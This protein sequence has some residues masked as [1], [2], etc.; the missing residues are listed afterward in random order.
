M[1]L[2]NLY[3][4]STTYLRVYEGGPIATPAAPITVGSSAAVIRDSI[5]QNR[6]M[7][8]KDLDKFLPRSGTYTLEVMHD[9]PFG[10]DVLAQFHPLVVDWKVGIRGT[11]YAGSQD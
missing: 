8:I 4:S 1:T 9:T 6:T 10:T 7:L 3:P 11:F 2:A 5:P